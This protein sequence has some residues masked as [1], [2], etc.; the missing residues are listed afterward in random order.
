M[1]EEDELVASLPVFLNGAP[2]GGADR[3]HGVRIGQGAHHGVGHGVLG[4]LL[5]RLVPLMGGAPPTVWEC[6]PART[7]GRALP[8]P[9][10]WIE[11]VELAFDQ[12]AKI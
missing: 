11:T 9:A 2:G 10:F 5:A 7:A 1:D 6:D 8:A 3:R 12:V 4:R